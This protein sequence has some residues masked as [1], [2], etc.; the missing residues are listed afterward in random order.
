MLCWHCIKKQPSCHQMRHWFALRKTL[1]CTH[2]K[3]L[4]EPWMELTCL[5]RCH[6]GIIYNREIE[7]VDLTEWPWGGGLR[8][9]LSFYLL[10]GWG[11]CQFIEQFPLTPV[12]ENMC[13]VYR[14]T[15]IYGVRDLLTIHIHSRVFD[16]VAN[17]FAPPL[18]KYV[19]G[20]CWI[21]FNPT[22]FFFINSL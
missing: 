6:L 16:A 22:C 10:P 20:R 7:R 5:L 12:S 3:T 19:F 21:V 11:I 15:I 1:K 8:Y 18:W 14:T 2:S 9:E 17:G 4:L 13:V